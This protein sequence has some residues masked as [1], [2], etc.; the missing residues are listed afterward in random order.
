MIF[1]LKNVQTWSKTSSFGQKSQTK[2][3]KIHFKELKSEKIPKLLKKSKVEPFKIHHHKIFFNLLTPKIELFC[4]AK[5]FRSRLCTEYVH[6]PP[7]TEKCRI[8]RGQ[9]FLNTLYE[10]IL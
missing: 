10:N 1:P 9:I 6:S 8:K 3:A 4:L 7:I 5:Y 2:L